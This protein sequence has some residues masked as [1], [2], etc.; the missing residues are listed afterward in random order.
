M[1]A[2][3]VYKSYLGQTHYCEGFQTKTKAHNKGYAFYQG[4]F[5]EPRLERASQ[6]S[7]ADIRN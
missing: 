4:N 7:F 3:H 6:L 5:R 2:L 1:K